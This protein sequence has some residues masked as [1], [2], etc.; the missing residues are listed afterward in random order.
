MSTRRRTATGLARSAGLVAAATLIAGCGADGPATG[1]DG[2]TGA[3]T[4]TV[5]AASSLTV[6]FEELAEDFEA[7]HEGVTVE[8][9]LAGSS[10]LV[11]QIRQGAPADVFAS[12]DQANME[13]L[14][15]EDLQGSAPVDFATNTLEVAVPPD[16]PSGVESLDDLAGDL[17]LVVCAPVVPCGAATGQV[18]DA[19]GVEL[20]PVSEEQSVTDVL[21]KV[22]SG[23]ADAGLVYV[24]DVAAAGDAVEGIPFPEADSVVNTY[25]I[26][27]VRDSEHADLAREFV[28]HVTSDAGRQVLTDLGFGAP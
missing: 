12:A 7:D 1:A 26:A 11:A 9:S 23:E 2:D 15:A 24:T 10:D 18:A 20:Q 16:N 25:P 19:A 27:T 14:T 13:K 21:N 17:D 4:L 3:T 6:A 28:D 5:F 8:V 22:V